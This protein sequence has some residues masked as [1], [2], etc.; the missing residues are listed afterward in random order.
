MSAIQHIAKANS[1]NFL[2]FVCS[3]LFFLLFRHKDTIKRRILQI[4]IVTLEEFAIFLYI[5]AVWE[6]EEKSGYDIETVLLSPNCYK[7]LQ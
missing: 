7:L 1:K 6:M 2:I 4:I 5:K 3:K